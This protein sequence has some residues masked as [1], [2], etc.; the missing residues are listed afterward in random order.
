[1]PRCTERYR[2]IPRETDTER[3]REARWDTERYRK[4]QTPRDT[5]RYRERP[6]ETDTERYREIR[7]GTEKYRKKR[8]PRDTERYREKQIP[9]DTERHQ[10]VDTLFKYDPTTRKRA[11]SLKSKHVRLRG[12]NCEIRARSPPHR[13]LSTKWRMRV[14][15]WLTSQI[16]RGGCSYTYIYT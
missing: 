14:A 10:E 9:I 11:W 8:A 6:R 7:C 2:E 13:E 15:R 3:Y 16:T 12:S 4:E 5:E 1:M